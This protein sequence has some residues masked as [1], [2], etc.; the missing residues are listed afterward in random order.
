MMQRPNPL[1]IGV[2]LLVLS[3]AITAGLYLFQPVWLFHRADIRTAEKIISLVQAFRV[4]QGRLPETLD[5]I[6]FNDQNDRVFYQKINENEYCVWFG[7]TL[8]ESETYYSRN[9]KWE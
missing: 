2:A 7:T 3:V 5:E 9:N 6:G 1:R 4:R 8:G